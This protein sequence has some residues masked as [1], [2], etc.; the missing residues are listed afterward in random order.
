MSPVEPLP[1]EALYRP[2]DPAVLDF[3]TTDDLPDLREV[4]GQPRVVEALEFGVGIRQEGYNVFAL[5]P[6]GT[7]KRSLVRQFLE[8]RAAQE[9]VP[10]DWVYVNNFEDPLRPRALRLP[11]G[12]GVQLRRDM[13]R[14]VDSLRAALASAFESEEYQMRRQEIQE[15]FL[16]EQE[17]AFESLRRQAEAQGLT[18][19]R[20]PAGI[21]FAPMR[22]GRVM[23]PEEFQAL[24]EEQRKALETRIEAMQQELQ[25]A[26]RRMPRWQRKLHQALKDLNHEVARLIAEGQVEE[27]REK[28]TAH[29]E[30]VA[31]LDA[32]V[33]DVSE[34]VQDFLVD[35]GAGE[36]RPPG[37]ISLS[38]TL[39]PS[40]RGLNPLRR[41]QVNVLVDHSG[42]QHAPVVYEDNPTYPNLLGRIEYVPQMGVFVTDF[43]LIKAGALHRANGGYLILDV[44]KVLLQPFAWEGLKRALQS[45]QL[46]IE[47]PAQAFG[48]ISTAS[49]EPD[50]IPLNVKVALLGSPLLYYLLAALDPEFPQLFKVM[51]DFDDWMDRD[52]EGQRLYT[53]L[54]ASLVRKEGL[55]PF[56]RDAVARVLEHSARM[57]ED[58]EKLSLRMRSVT[59][60]L[61]EADY[62]AG[63]NGNG[64]VQA[65]DV[66]RAID[67]R[68]FRSDRLRAR[69]Q[70]AI[71]RETI[72]IDTEGERVGQVNGLSVLQLGDFAFGRP[73]RIT[74]R[75]RLGSG[76]VVD[77]EREVELSGPI[78]SKGVLILAGF[79]GARYAA[80][81]PLSL[82]ASLVFEQSYSG[83]EGDSAS[84]AELY[85]L[86]SAIAGVP[87]KQSLAVTGSVNQHGQIQAVGGVNEKIEGFFDVCRA[88]GLTGEQGVL[89]PAANVKNLM[90]RQDV[91]EAVR[92]GQFHIYPIETVDQ[93]IELLTG[94]PAG[95]PDEQGKY[96]EGTVNGMVQARL[97]EL[98]EKRAAFSRAAGE[99]EG[100]EEA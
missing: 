25:R 37:L 85:A 32:V 22:E 65:E 29:S 19:L 10:D 42:T 59:D 92:A 6:A 1:P 16:A 91:I 88:R 79:L 23:T 100:E 87:I 61:R 53:R 74:A 51:A 13:E 84:S 60:L 2:V 35:R 55:R 54:V 48:A 95:V 36:P 33:E 70:E 96:P 15:R 26:L 81:Q 14:L 8:R 17:Q 30:V 28:Y 45:R 38:P 89:I 24:P 94:L 86:I 27:L 71:L 21:V 93:G 31:Y 77:I 98:A 67:A 43:N 46:R 78:H 49:L 20:T 7:G 34:N 56:H 4:L 62:W 44:Q 52:G 97:A 9:P 90:L 47:T 12:T 11:A 73:S 83:V 63:R 18:M 3:E 99:K 69:I 40:H 50:A 66:Q 68:T 57:A 39:T 58:A 80:E 72:L 64:V 41:Y 76:E 75:V 5:G 82:S